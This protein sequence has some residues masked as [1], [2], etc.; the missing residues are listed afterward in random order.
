MKTPPEKVTKYLDKQHF[1]NW[2]LETIL[3]QNKIKIA[4]V[5]PVIEEYQFISQLLNSIGNNDNKYAHE[6]IFIFV[7]NK[8][9]SSDKKTREDNLKCL[10]LLRNIIDKHEGIARNYK[11]LNSNGWNIGVIDCSSPGKELPVKDSGV[12][13]ARKIGMDLALTLFDYSSPGKNII[14]C[15]D[16]DCTIE[17]N[18]ITEIN[19][20]FNERKI[21]SAV[22]NFEHDIDSSSETVEA[23]ICYEI[24]LRYYVLGL[25]FAGSPYAIHTIGST[26]TCDH[27]SYI[28]IGGMNKRKAAE[29]FYFLEKLV[30]NVNVDKITSTSVYPSSRGSWRVPFGTGQRVNRFLSKTQNEYLL[31]NPIGFFLLKDWLQIFNSDEIC[32]GE[33]YLEKATHLDKDLHQFLITQNFQQA[34]D[35]IL[36]NS[37]SSEQVN[38]QKKFW[39][40]GFKTMK[41]IH[42]L[43]DSAYPMIN[44]FD[45]LDELLMRIG[46]IEK[47]QRNK[48]PLP[49]LNI[50]KQ[51]LYLLRELDMH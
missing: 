4:V 19:K 32:T 3:Q 46:I 22:I 35:K 9:V 48:T 6:T 23:I 5:I 14:V 50:Q 1:N 30:K 25:R 13:F 34:W 21:S 26:I 11:K 24:F 43:R 45:A 31:Y 29:D 51:Y 17:N 8:P 38:L 44:M 7:I 36:K 18:Y 49:G 37:G 28:K 27:K 10:N 47:V 16:A 41:L 39:F 20:A 42:H 15:L 40:D 12:G 2:I 33:Q